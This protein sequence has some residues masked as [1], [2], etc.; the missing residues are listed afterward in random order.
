MRS[1]LVLRNKALAG[2]GPLLWL[3]FVGT[4][5]SVSWF[6]FRLFGHYRSAGK[7]IARLFVGV[8][9]VLLLVSALQA[10][11]PPYRWNVFKGR[12]QDQPNIILVTLDTL[13]ADHLS[14]YGYPVRTSPFMDSISKQAVFFRN[15]YT[16]ATWT[17]PAHGSLF[18]GQMPSVNGLGF[19]NFFLSLKTDTLAKTLKAKG[20]TTGGFIGGPFLVSAFHVNQGFD[21]YNEHL[22]RN[23]KL[24]RF[25]LFTLVSR[26]LKRSIQDGS[27][28]KAQILPAECCAPC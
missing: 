9:V 8:F 27:K 15:A 16:S 11:V 14:C 18:T 6:L 1:I 3:A 12:G 21:F 25:E 10:L 5:V 17:L 28:R 20:Y 2:T 4:A 19:Q 26:I 13:R 24:R 23:S 22:D 7:W